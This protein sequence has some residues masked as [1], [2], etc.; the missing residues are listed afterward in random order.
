M[1][2]APKLAGMRSA[3]AI[4]EA[5]LPERD[6][7]RD[8]FD[9]TVDLLDAMAAA[10]G[11]RLNYVRWELSLL[12]DLGF[13]LDLSACAVTGATEDLTFVSPRTGRAVSSQAAQPYRDR[14][15]RL[16]GFL[17]DDRVA[18]ADGADIA[19]GLALTGYFLERQMLA[20]SGTSLPPARARFVVM[21]ARIPTISGTIA[22]P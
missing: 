21:L 10:P 14:L 7:H 22:M 2:D 6:P 13:G 5:G 9:S 17:L 4:L 20:P 1:D 16:P 15:L 3:C 18:V 11:W 19:A 8:V 12:A